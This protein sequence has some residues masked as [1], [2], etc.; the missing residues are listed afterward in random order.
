MANVSHN[1]IYSEEDEYDEEEG[2]L[3]EAEY[4]DTSAS[5]YAANSQSSTESENE[6][7]KRKRPKKK[8]QSD[9]RRKGENQNEDSPQI[10]SL[11]T[12]TS[13]SVA[14]QKP[15]SKC[16]LTK[17][18]IGSTWKISNKWRFSSEL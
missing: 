12:T 13:Q 17:S 7:N 14:A 10:Q 8:N 6:N 1:E 5:K 11:D 2:R 16:T 9:K 3:S 18:E 4:V 15:R